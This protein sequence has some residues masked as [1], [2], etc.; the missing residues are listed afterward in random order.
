M[1]TTHTPFTAPASGRSR[2]LARLVAAGIASISLLALAGCGDDDPSGQGTASPGASSAAATDSASPSPSPAPSVKPS[3]NLDAIT[4]KGDYG[5]KPKIK[6]KAPW[7][8]KETQSEVLTQGDGA[9]VLE[10]G[11]V[12][13]NYT[14]VNG[15]TGETFD[16]SFERGQPVT[17]PLDGVIPGFKKGLVGKHVG[18]RV[19]IAMTGEDGYDSSGGSPQAGI[20][21][22]DTLIFVADITGTTLKS[23][24]GKD[25]AAK[26]GLPTVKMSGDKPTVS[27]PDSD[28]PA[29]KT[30][31]PL[32][33]GDGAKV[34]KNDTVTTR[35]VTVLWKDGKVVD[36][37]WGQRWT[38]DAQSGETRLEA[39]QQAM[40][41]HRVG[42]RLIMV[43]PPGTAYKTGDKG[44]GITKDD[45][46]VMVVDILFT[47][48]TG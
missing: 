46:V 8:I 18:D 43:F 38:P 20:N 39:M 32:I 36:D 30:V 44:Q 29:K 3:E 12:E 26:D 15:R 28:P 17:F 34:G 47:Q 5:D 45:T 25:V 21:V 33:K 35:S 9:E 19:L 11:N 27:I 37:S 41:G 40:V 31:Q 42:D 1:R 10:D 7:A 4:V 6:V 16:S 13:V 22:G 23:A 14:G 48:Q 24:E 2:R